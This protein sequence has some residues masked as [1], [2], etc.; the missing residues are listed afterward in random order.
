MEMGLGHLLSSM[1]AVGVAVVVIMA[2]MS[3]WGLYVTFERLMAFRNA[4]KESLVFAKQVTQLLAQD[5][6]QDA[7][8]HFYRIYAPLCEGWAGELA[9]HARGRGGDFCRC[10]SG[11][12]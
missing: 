11:H 10:R 1:S 3:I 2:I 5:R 4:K 9:G 6:V 12:G 7:M 8:T